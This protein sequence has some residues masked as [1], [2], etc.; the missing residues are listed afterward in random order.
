MT[1]K[2]TRRLLIGIALIICHLTFS[3]A[4][5][6]CSNDY[7]PTYLDKVRVS[8]SYIGFA[9]QGSTVT[10]EVV[11]A[12][13][14]TITDIPEWVTVSPASGQAGKT[15][16]SFTTTAATATNEATVILEC[17]GAKQRI[18]LIQM[19]AKA[20]AQLVSCAQVI[21]GN[22]GVT[23]RVKG[24]CAS[25]PDNQYGNWN[26][27]DET[28]QVYIYG[29]LD[30]KGGKGTYP[31]RGENGWGFGVG[32]IVT[33]EGPMKNYN[34]TIEL[35]DVTVV[36]IDKSLIKCDSLSSNEPL[37]IEGGDV[38]AFVTC[39]SNGFGLTIPDEAKTWLSVTALTPN[40][41]TFHAMANSGA[42]RSAVVVL[43]TKSDGVEYTA[44]VTIAQKGVSQGSGTEADPYNVAAA[45]SF[46]RAL[47]ADVKSEQDIYVKGIISSVKYTYSA[48]FGTATYNISD[49]GSE[50]G[51]FTVY[52]SYYFDNKPWTEGDDQI[53]VG[54]EVVVCGKAI[55][56]KG[57]TPEFSNKENWLVSLNGKTS[58]QAVSIADFLAAEVGD[59]RYSLTGMITELYASDKQGKS[60]YI[61]DHTG[62]TLIYRAE[63]F[64]EAGAKV[65]DVVTVVG[66]RGAYKDSPQMVEGNMT[67]LNF[68][69]QPISIADFRNL[70][71]N[72]EKYY[73]LSGTI[74]E[75]TE[76]GTKNDVETYGNFNLTDDSGSVYIYGVINGWG[77]AKGHFGSLGIGFGDKLTIIAYK[78][79]YKG[80]VEGVGVYLS[81]EKKQ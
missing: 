24:I 49:D 19:T 36:S 2:T 77:G 78:T 76:D 29:T 71:D 53:K 60:F 6:S 74:T 50:N 27:Q 28:G 5:V 12:A 22:E 20:E 54:D 38:T 15:E 8:Q 62:T 31:M 73:L 59:A 61:A 32:D 52:G 35:V 34:G 46:T 51:V 4:I 45:I 10:I 23:Y 25:D 7:D 70:E 37:P 63:G 64:I 40:S 67:E 18:N 47:G 39:K 69:V 41:V 72:K 55:Y 56:Y 75:A 57:T 26:I 65:G 33:V 1:A 3:G 66:K 17:G 48:D 79:T 21:A 16:V 14:W 30:K 43:N 42:D 9:A 44:Q 80:L 81:H 68:A 11:A 58:F 13:D